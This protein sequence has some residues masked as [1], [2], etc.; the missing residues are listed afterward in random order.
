ML[1]AGLGAAAAGGALIAAISGF[2]PWAVPLLL[3]S[4]GALVLRRTWIQSEQDYALARASHLEALRREQLSIRTGY[5]LEKHGQDGALVARLERK[6]LWVGE[7]AEQVRDALGEPEGV[8]V[9]PLKTRRREVWKYGR[10]GRNRYST[11]ITLDNGTVV[12]WQK[13][14]RPPRTRS[15]HATNS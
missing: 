7:T 1:P 12:R 10:T 2:M 15:H 9:K 8:D 13:R 11:R 14:E 4:V 6:E 5:L 3:C